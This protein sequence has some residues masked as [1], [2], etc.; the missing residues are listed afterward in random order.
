MRETVFK[1]INTILALV[2]FVIVW[3]VVSYLD[4]TVELC[5]EINWM[6]VVVT[7]LFGLSLFVPLVI[8]TIRGER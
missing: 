8:Y 3:G 6:R 1:A 4:N 5:A 2:G 7:V